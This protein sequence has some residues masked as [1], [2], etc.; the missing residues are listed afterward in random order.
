MRFK[1]NCYNYKTDFIIPAFNVEKGAQNPFITFSD[2]T[3]VYYE[4]KMLRP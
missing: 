2:G 1:C 4:E 3:K